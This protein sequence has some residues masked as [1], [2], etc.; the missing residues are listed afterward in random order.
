VEWFR[1]QAGEGLKEWS[2]P[3]LE[4]HVT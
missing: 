3:T 4:P 2:P 1:H